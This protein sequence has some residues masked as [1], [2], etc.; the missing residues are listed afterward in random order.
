[1][2]TAKHPWWCTAGEGEMDVCRLSISPA[3]CYCILVNFYTVHIYPYISVR[4]IQMECILL[5]DVVIF[6]MHIYAYMLLI[7]AYSFLS[8]FDTY[9]QI[10]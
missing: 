10:V 1:M 6:C 3:F 2:A 7:Y 9:C 4:L 5:N 8:F